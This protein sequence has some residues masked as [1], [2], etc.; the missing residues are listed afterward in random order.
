MY[1]KYWKLSRKP[2]A[3]KF[4][5]DFFFASEEH[6]ECLVRLLYAVDDGKGLVVLTGP[7]GSGK[8]F[9]LNHLQHKLSLQR[10]PV[11]LVTNPCNGCGLEVLSQVLD[12]FRYQGVAKT[13]REMIK[14]FQAL[15]REARSRGKRLVVLLDEADTISDPSIFEELRL[16]TNLQDNGASSLTLVLAGTQRL[17]EILA[18]NARLAHRVDLY[19]E[20]H[21]MEESDSCRYIQHRV[22][23]CQGQRGLFEP[24]AQREI[25]FASRGNPRLINSICDLSLLIGCSAGKKTVDAGLVRE[26]NSENR[27]HAPSYV[28]D[29]RS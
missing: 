20:L 25:H 29:H 8:T 5:S 17:R 1:E 27:H 24:Q 12:G 7:S 4:D 22:E 15:S 11:S 18:S 13:K 2:F 19:A 26:A 16:L 21:G 6:K 28:K 10:F 9:I 3:N 23:V 14:A